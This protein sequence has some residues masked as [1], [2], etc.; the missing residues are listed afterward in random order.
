V[1]E[2][3]NN[4]FK[5]YFYTAL[6]I[7]FRHR[8]CNESGVLHDDVPVKWGKI[9]VGKN[10]RLIKQ[11]IVLNVLLATEVGLTT[12]ATSCRA[13]K[14]PRK[15][16]NRILYDAARVMLVGHSDFC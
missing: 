1:H 15:T 7:N 13:Q 6:L 8:L 10:I 11:E 14:E 9:A 2:V 16:H 5:A 12:W 3:W 4:L